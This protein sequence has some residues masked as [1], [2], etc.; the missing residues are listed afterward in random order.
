M[1]K[2][3]VYFVFAFNMPN[4]REIL[5]SLN[6]VCYKFFMFFL[7]GKEIIDEKLDFTVF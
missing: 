6:T 4:N 5:T 7:R 1:C 3:L 2:R